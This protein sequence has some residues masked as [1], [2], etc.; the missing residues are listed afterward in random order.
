MTVC[1]LCPRQC[2]V[3]RTTT[4]GFCGMP[5]GFRVARAA[6]HFWE[7]PCISGKNGS[8][9]IFFSGCTLRCGFCQ[10]YEIST[11]GKGVDISDERLVQ[12]LFE[13]KAQ[14][15]HNINLVTPDAFAARLAPLLAR[16]KAA[17]GLPIVF[18][19]SGYES[20]ALLKA[21]E[22]IVDVYL[23][24]FKYAD[25]AL[26]DRLSCAADY[27]QVA[28]KALKLMFSQVGRPKWDGEGHLIR[29]MMVRHLVLPGYRQNSRAVMAKLAEWFAPEDILLSLMSQYT[30][31]GRPGMP[32]RPLTHF[33]Y[34]SVKKEALAAGFAG[35]FQELS[36]VGACFT[37]YFDG[38]GVHP[39][40]K[41]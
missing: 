23:P 14:G 38:E 39:S 11:D 1:S 3:D 2:G 31:C 7:E 29:G 22:G 34:D 17:L 18:N 35:Y 40:P 24:D 10:N 27:P 20:P 19:G 21:M 28:E 36:S 41:V 25:P 8:G 6:P 9:A 4:L 5:D 12:I 26:A 32:D 16:E 37:P 33:E 13:L 30:P 15:V